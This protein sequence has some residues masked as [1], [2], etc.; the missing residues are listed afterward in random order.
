MRHASTQ[1]NKHRYYSTKHYLQRKSILGYQSWNSQLQCIHEKIDVDSNASL[2][3]KSNFEVMQS[4][5]IFEVNGRL[6]CDSF[7]LNRLREFKSNPGTW[8][9]TSSP[10]VLST[11]ATQDAFET[12]F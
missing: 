11:D 7:Y 8:I 3:L 10:T 12:P 5:L 6:I 1:S 9:E 4:G 2:Q